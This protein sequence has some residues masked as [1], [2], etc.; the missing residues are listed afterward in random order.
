MLAV[1][2]TNDA[3][4]GPGAGFKSVPLPKRENK[5][6]G[7][8]TENVLLKNFGDIYMVER[9]ALAESGVRSIEV[10]AIVD[11]GATYLCLPP[12]VI[13]ELGLIYSHTMQ[14]ITA[15]GS[16]QRRIFSG[17]Q[18]R[19]RDRHTEMPVMENEPATPPLIGYMVLEALDFLVD[20]K[21]QAL[22][23]NPEHDGKW[24]AELY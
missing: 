16:V 23:P 7:R 24:V 1:T 4:L 12:S 2:D 3:V 18:I 5:V 14:I 15:N 21:S 6:V 8:T 22:I 9:K 20:P 10:E 17:A 11:T 19:I 13:E